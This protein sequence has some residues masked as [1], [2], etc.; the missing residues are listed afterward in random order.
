MTSCASGAALRM[1]ARIFFRIARTFGGNLEMYSSMLVGGPT[2]GSTTLS[3]PD[4]LGELLATFD[5]V[6]EPVV[7]GT[8]GREQYDIARSGTLQAPRDGRRERPLR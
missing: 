8:A 4:Q 1:V 5:V 7:A 2:E 6:L 3:S